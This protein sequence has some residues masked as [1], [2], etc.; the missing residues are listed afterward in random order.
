[1]KLIKI[2]ERRTY[3]ETGITKPVLKSFLGFDK[4]FQD[5][6]RVYDGLI[7][8]LYEYAFSVLYIKR[9]RSFVCC[10]SSII[11][12]CHWIINNLQ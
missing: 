4:D 3:T 10:C 2:I 1:M 7:V 6:L 11:M 5:R 12:P 9:M 8:V